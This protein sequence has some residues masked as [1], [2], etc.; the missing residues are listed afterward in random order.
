LRIDLGSGD[1][2][3]VFI[4]LNPSTAD[5]FTNDPTIERLCRRAK[6][7][8]YRELVVC[9]IFALRS[10]DPKGLLGVEDPI[11]P[12]NERYILEESLSASMVLCGWGAPSQLKN[13]GN[14]IKSLLRQNDVGLHVLALN[15]DESPKHPL[16]VSYGTV[17]TV[18]EL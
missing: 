10:T 14:K 4:G 15:K 12:E 7:M 16:Y 8:G 17:P 3:M 11:G 1:G 9:N 5:E 13:Q 2:K 6:R 18:W